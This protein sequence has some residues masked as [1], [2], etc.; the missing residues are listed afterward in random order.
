MS[1]ELT[2]TTRARRL[3]AT[4]LLAGCTLAATACGSV[5]DA[6]GD[7]NPGP[8]VEVVTATGGDSTTTTPPPPASFEVAGQWNWAFETSDGYR[9]EGT[10]YLG[11]VLR[12]SE[13]PPL[14]GFSDAEMDLSSACD[15]FD[16]TT[17]AVVPAKL[18]L[19][20][21][22]PSFAYSLSNSLFLVLDDDAVFSSR[23]NGDEL[24]VAASYSDGVDCKAIGTADDVFFG[25]GSSWGLSYET[26][27]GPDEARPAHHA[28]LI[29]PNYY[30]P[31]T[32]E[33]DSARLGRTGLGLVAAMRHDDAELV[34]LT[35]PH[36]A[37]GPAQGA[38]FLSSLV[39][40]ATE[41][42]AEEPVPP[43]PP[44]DGPDTDAT[45]DADRTDATDGADQAEPEVDLTG[46]P[47]VRSGTWSGTWVSPVAGL[48][49]SVRVEVELDDTTVTGS[50]DLRG[51]SHATL[52]DSGPLSGTR[53][54]LTMSLSVAD[55]TLELVGDISP[56]GSTF[57]GTY[58][59]TLNRGTITDS[60]TFRLDKD[61]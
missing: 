50:L 48:D 30:A 53:D 4:V 52:V 11:A 28:Y 47:E 13:A 46:C 59:A 39:P 24:A 17:S 16:P 1:K 3:G 10:L 44:I 25:S 37:F 7:S 49:G 5:V 33:G 60:G 58:E 14:P 15:S 27:T 23:S 51:P 56:D 41:A 2:A 54:C 34:E 12:A 6:H 19:R 45:A 36:S 26:E 42:D 22:T 61:R 18:V 40:H 35:G 9:T 57:T 29:L 38:F 31:N 21:G 8:A 32:P 43:S 20:N 55:D